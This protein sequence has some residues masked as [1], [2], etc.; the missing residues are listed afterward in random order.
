M[1]EAAEKPTVPAGALDKTNGF[2]HGNQQLQKSQVRHL[3]RGRRLKFLLQPTWADQQV[4]AI[5]MVADGAQEWDTCTKQQD[6][7]VVLCNHCKRLHYLQKVVSGFII[8]S[9]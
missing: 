5:L 4:V 7:T 3:R 9:R 6:E 1:A 2:C 8:Y